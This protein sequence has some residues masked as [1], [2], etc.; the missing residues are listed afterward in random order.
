M[1]KYRVKLISAIILIILIALK[2]I[3]VFAIEEKN[4]INTIPENNIID[5]NKSIELKNKQNDNK[6]KIEESYNTNNIENNVNVLSNDK[7]TIEDGIYVIRSSINPKYVL[8]V[9]GA[10][11]VNG[12]NVQLYEY[13][14]DKQKRFKVRS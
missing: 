10:S 13:S 12:A 7:R 5:S 4:S 9:N 11:N 2:T 14:A 8:D 3:T 1:C 6:L